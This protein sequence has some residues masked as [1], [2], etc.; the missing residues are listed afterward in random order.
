[1]SHG[2]NLKHLEQEIENAAL[3]ERVWLVTLI[4]AFFYYKIAAKSLM[5]H[6]CRY[7][8]LDNNKV[9]VGLGDSL[10]RIRSPQLMLHLVG[11]TRY[12][13]SY[14][15]NLTHKRAR[16][17]EGIQRAAVNYL[18]R[19]PRALHYRSNRSRIR[20]MTPLAVE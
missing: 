19:S 12:N 6:A 5:L 4:R 8:D 9:V 16:C 2:C 17:A 13:K 3:S 1:M 18:T 20:I 10:S 14:L 11:G 7:A 15:F